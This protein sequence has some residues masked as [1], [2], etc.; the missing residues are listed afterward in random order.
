[1]AINIKEL[2]NA[3][4]DNIK[5]DKTNYNF[6][7]IL[8]NGGGPIGAKGEQGTTGNTGTKGQKGEL[9][10][11]G[12]EGSK[13][14]QGTSANLWDSD[15]LTVGNNDFTVLRPYNLEADGA[16]AFRT[17]VILGQAT[18]VDPNNPTLDT[19][20][21]EPTSLLTLEL[22][23]AD[24]NDVTAQLIFINDESVGSPKEFKMATSYESGIG[25]TF[26]FSALAGIMD[27]ETNLSIQMPNKITLDASDLIR[28]GTQSTLDVF[29]ESERLLDLLSDEMLD[30]TANDSMTL[31]A[32]GDF[33]LTSPEIIL[34]GT[35]S[36]FRIRTNGNAELT[37][38]GGDINIKSD[39]TASGAVII[40]SDLSYDPAAVVYGVRVGDQTFATQVT[41]RAKLKLSST[42]TNSIVDI[43]AGTSGTI[44]M[45][46]GSVSASKDKLEVSET[47]TT[48]HQTSLFDQAATVIDQTTASTTLDSG[49][50]IQFIEGGNFVR[51][52]S[53]GPSGFNDFIGFYKAGNYGSAERER[54]LSDYFHKIDFDH[55]VLKAFDTTSTDGFGVNAGTRGNLVAAPTGR[56]PST[57]ITLGSTSFKEGSY[58]KIGDNVQGHGVIKAGTV[59]TNAA[60]TQDLNGSLLGYSLY[61]D[62]TT[63]ISDG[64]FNDNDKFVFPYLNSSAA[65]VQCEIALS[66]ESNNSS[67]GD[68]PILKGIIY[69]G[70]SR[71]F[72]YR[73][74]YD[75]NKLFWRPVSPKDI[76]GSN[77]TT[78]TL[79]FKFSFQTRNINSYNRKYLN[80]IF[81]FLF[82]SD[83]SLK[84]NLVK[85]GESP[86]GYNIYQF[87]FIDDLPEYLIEE[88]G[89]DPTGH[90]F[91]GVIADELPNEFVMRHP[92]E[93]FDRV[94][95]NEI[96]VEFKL[97]KENV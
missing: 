24:N 18:H 34:N 20:P 9:G 67:L 89:I 57:Q 92:D 56:T 96:D 6:D 71:I 44:L 62:L 31:T 88:L 39:S 81:V 82:P 91:Q 90:L 29:I 47:I 7:Q 83:R 63:D 19:T 38:N 85:V 73:G 49:E 1:M 93:D 74:W 51:N 61:I 94:N 70:T 68:F 26:T 86:S 32:N 43:S 95:Y 33:T 11:K 17:R 65:P 87:N 36:F 28:I 52:E 45:S 64:Y 40:R 37:T 10:N 35:N 5:V 66:T 84:T 58:I 23:P 46:V 72:I 75:N 27:E 4:A 80:E 25:S 78:F 53:M 69:P 55:W 48:H 2:F 42:Q 60:W 16:D 8:A 77:G 12:N 21:T 50:G 22:P 13:G 41:G 97:I 59:S 3:D 30:I 54:T 76:Y 79:S 15:S 14:E